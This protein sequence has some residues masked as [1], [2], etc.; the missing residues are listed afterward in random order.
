MRKNASEGVYR[1][2]GGVRSPEAGC[3]SG[4][5][6]VPRACCG[7]WGPGSRRLPIQCGDPDQV[8]DG[9]RD[10][11]P[12]SVAPSAFVPELAA[13]A[14]GL[15][16][17]ERFLDTFADPLAHLMSGVAGG[18]SVDG[19]SSVGGVLRDVGGDPASP[20]FGHEARGVVGLVR[21]NRPS[22][23]AFREPAEHLRGR[24]PFGSAVGLSQF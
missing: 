19:A 8:V 23:F 4:S 7:N 17:A 6:G 12:G 14:Y 13:A 3:P 24:L 2:L 10:E 11:E 18:A 15:D 21:G 5:R 9:T 16:P 20:A 22:P 1:L